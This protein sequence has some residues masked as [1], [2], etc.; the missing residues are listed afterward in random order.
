[1]GF[2]VVVE[3]GRGE[4]NR[5]NAFVMEE[6]MFYVFFFFLPDSSDSVT[7]INC[8]HLNVFSSF[9]RKWGNKP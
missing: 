8:S 9:L 2:G 1:M 7:G 3:V 5:G 4:D 6:K